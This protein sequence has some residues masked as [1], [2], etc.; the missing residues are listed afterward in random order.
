MRSAVPS[1]NAVD[2]RGFFQCRIHGAQGAG[3]E[4]KHDRR[5][6]ERHHENEAGER[7]DIERRARHAEHAGEQVVE[8]ADA[9]IGKQRPGD[10]AD[11]GREVV[12]DH[13]HVVEETAR[14]RIGAAGDPGQHDAH[15]DRDDCRQRRGDQRVNDSV[16]VGRIGEQRYEIGQRQMAGPHR[17]R[18]ADAADQ[19]QRH[20]IE[21]EPGEQ[22]DGDD[23]NDHFGLRP[24]IAGRRRPTGPRGTS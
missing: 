6:V 21:D 23:A 11:K 4:Q 24:C 19:Q 14:R 15:R 12:R 17:Q 16:E 5:I 18:G 3:D 1:A 7:I 22:R 8:E 9:R 20:G 13:E 10:G 2:A